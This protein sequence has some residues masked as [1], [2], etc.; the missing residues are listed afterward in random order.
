MKAR[1]EKERLIA[2]HLAEQ[3]RWR[4]SVEEEKKNILHNFQN[5]NRLSWLMRIH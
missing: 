1:V 3:Q 5:M 4:E 2:L